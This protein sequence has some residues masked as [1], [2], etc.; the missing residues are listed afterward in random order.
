MRSRYWT[1]SKFADWLRGTPKP[2]A[3]TSQGWNQWNRDAKKD[4]PI[5]YWLA[6]EGLSYLQDF[7]MWPLDKL[8]AVK[9]Y[10]NNRWVSRSHALTANTRDI[11]PGTWCDVGNRFLPCL[12]NELVDFVEIELAWAHLRWDSKEKREQYNAPWWRFG[13]WNMRFWRCP[14]AGLDNLEW[15]R[16][17]VGDYGDDKDKP[18]SQAIAAQEVLD[19]YN[20][21]TVT[22]P[23]RPDP[24]D[25]SG[26]T[27]YNERRKSSITGSEDFWDIMS[28]DETED[29]REKNRRL[30]DISTEIENK[31]EQEDEEMLIRLIKVRKSL[32]T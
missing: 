1:C 25:V 4:H 13:W 22:R 10:I 5:R 27:A 7:V 14:Q 16:T 23:A 11:R 8:H 32:W 17:L 30:L 21:W 12:F 20:W 29:E 15:Q 28:S 19:L 24:Y 3:L 31:Y 6:E 9:Y 18:T 26:W 2:G